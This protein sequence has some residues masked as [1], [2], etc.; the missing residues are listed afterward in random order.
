VPFAPGEKLTYVLRWE[1]IPAGKATLEV[2]SIKEM[3]GAAAYHFV[4]TAQSNKFVDFF[5]KIRDRID[6]YA[7]I[8]MRHSVFYKKNQSEGAH[9]KYETIEF[10]WEKNQ[11]RYSE[12]GKPRNPIEL[13]PGS[14]DPLSAF[15][16]TRVALTNGN[17]ELVERPVTDGKKNIIGRAKVV[18]RETLT[19]KNGK[20]YDTILLEPEMRH[21]GGVFKESKDAKIYLWVTADERCIPVQIK[22]KVVVGHF[23]GELVDTEGLK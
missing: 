19:L 5:Y 6:A 18:G 10:D 12:P 17:P 9:K 2:H 20:T 21:I 15:Y 4:M 16:F 3:N 14:F 8:D 23:V 7:D 11:A 1:N 22:S 13:K